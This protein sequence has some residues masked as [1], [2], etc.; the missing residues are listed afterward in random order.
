MKKTLLQKLDDKQFSAYCDYTI[1][2]EGLKLWKE[3]NPTYEKDL[4]LWIESMNQEI[5]VQTMKHKYD[6]ALLKFGIENTKQHF[7]NQND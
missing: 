4:N 2:D 1:L 7:Q 6:I 3:K 5:I